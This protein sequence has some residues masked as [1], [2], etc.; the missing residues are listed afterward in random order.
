MAGVDFRCGFAL[1]SLLVE[2]FP[3]N[4]IARHL[5]GTNSIWLWA[6][7]FAKRLNALDAERV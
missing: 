7:Q 1:Q 3:F 5:F 6:V 2:L 4:G